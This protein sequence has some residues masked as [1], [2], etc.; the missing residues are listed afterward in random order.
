MI[1]VQK[2]DPVLY[3]LILENLALNSKNNQNIQHLPPTT[4]KATY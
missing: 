3:K 2:V 4:S 1:K